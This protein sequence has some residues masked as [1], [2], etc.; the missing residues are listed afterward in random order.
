MNARLQIS[1]SMKKTLI[2]KGAKS[3]TELRSI[4]R[5]QDGDGII[6]TLLNLLPDGAVTKILG[7][8]VLG[9]IGAALLKRRSRPQPQ[10]QHQAPQLQTQAQQSIPMG[11]TPY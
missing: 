9:G 7:G 3:D 1:Q 4:M 6:G 8:A 10:S 5:S 2:D 11:Y